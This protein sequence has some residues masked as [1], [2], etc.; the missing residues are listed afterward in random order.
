MPSDDSLHPSSR[1]CVSKAHQHAVRDHKILFSMLYQID[2]SL[3]GLSSEE[4]VTCLANV[5]AYA[6]YYGLLPFIAKSLEH[7]FY[8]QHIRMDSD[9]LERP[10]YWLALGY[11]LRSEPVFADALR[12][13]VGGDWIHSFAANNPD[14]QD[15][16]LLTYKKQLELAQSISRTDQE[17]YRVTL[18]TEHY[19]PHK[20]PLR[21]TFL[22]EEKRAKKIKSEEAKARYLA[23]KTLGD[24][25]A[26]N[27]SKPHCTYVGAPRNVVYPKLLR[28]ASSADISIFGHEAASR[29]A[30]IFYLEV[31][32]SKRPPQQVIEME[33]RRALREVKEVLERHLFPKH[34][35]PAQQEPREL[36]ETFGKYEKR[37]YY[38]THMSIMK[39]EMPW[40][41]ED[42]WSPI[43][44]DFEIKP[45]S[46]AWLEQVGLGHLEA[47]IDGVAGGGGAFFCASPMSAACKARG[48]HGW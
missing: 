36:G 4:L 6:E 28:L 25:L 13:F 38:L 45:A 16:I 1:L 2:V 24:W 11:M 7:G 10:V 47:E 40:V 18:V 5:A 9:I 27:I 20:T 12:H 41:N 42:R 30:S 22:S 3:I 37:Q 35:P 26:E 44:P 19:E 46:K 48:W 32:Q 31:G 15:V 29:L 14:W 33:M 39:E 34:C 8:H 17:L 21:F 23:R 43:T